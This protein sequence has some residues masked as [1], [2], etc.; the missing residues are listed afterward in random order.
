MTNPEQ[1]GFWRH[2]C[3]TGSV[4]DY[5]AYRQWMS[6]VDKGQGEA[7]F[8]NDGDELD[9]NNDRWSGGKTEEHRG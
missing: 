2:F 3:E 9:A 6:R 1:E 4:D 7:D 5:I 8:F